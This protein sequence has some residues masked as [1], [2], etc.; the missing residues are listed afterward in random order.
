MDAFIPGLRLSEQFYRRCVVPILRR[1]FPRLRYSA[2]LIGPGSEV[3]GFDDAESTDHHWGLRLILFMADD[4]GAEP[5]RAV[6]STLAK[7]LPVSFIG[8]STNFTPPN[9]LDHG[10]R[11]PAPIECGP[12]NHMIELTTPRR[13]FRRQLGVDPFEPVTDR[14]WMTLSQQSLLE[15]TGGRIFHDGL[16]QLERLRRRFAYYPREVWIELLARQWERISEHEAFVGRTGFRGDELGSRLIA[17]GQVR[18]LMELCFL[19]ERR[20]AP[21]AKWFGTA[22]MKLRRARRLSPIFRRVLEARTWRH[23][24]RHLSDA[25][26]SVVAMQNAMKITAEVP[27]RTSRYHG[28]PYQVI[29]GEAIARE[30][31]RAL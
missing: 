5:R 3:L 4:Q 25:Y 12:V 28:R 14:R 8:H 29:H 15:V 2:G 18:L 26:H 24:E 7:E 31:R 9:S 10:V 1:R 16:K 19:L 30:L 20:Y 22:F 23:R 6:S 21:Y 17:A 11:M 27:E 13:F